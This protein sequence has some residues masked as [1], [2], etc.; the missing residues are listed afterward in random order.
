MRAIVGGNA[1]L[2][3][4]LAVPGAYLL[5]IR[6]AGPLA[7]DIATLGPAPLA[8]GLY[9]YD[10]SARGPGGIA[11]RVG[12]HLRRTKRRHWHVDRLTG[13]GRVVAV[14]AL[15]GGDECSLI[16]RLHPHPGIVAP[17]AGFGASDCRRGCPAH[18]L[19]IADAAT[20]DDALALTAGLVIRDPA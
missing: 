9:L 18:L 15:V 8:P 5:A 12:R 3:D 7:L 14:A 1:G 13:A 16:A 4:I 11:A 17:V 6:L 20:L 19:S 10:G 2:A